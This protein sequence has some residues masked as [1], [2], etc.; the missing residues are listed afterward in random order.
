M[1][2]MNLMTW[3]QCRNVC[4]AW[5]L[6]TGI[7][8]QF[9]K[10]EKGL[11]DLI[12]NTDDK[13]RHLVLMS[14]KKYLKNITLPPTLNVSNLQPCQPKYRGLM[15]LYRVIEQ[16]I[17]SNNRMGSKIR[18]RHCQQLLLSNSIKGVSFFPSS[19]KV[20]DDAGCSV[21]AAQLFLQR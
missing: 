20:M 3:R 18:S 13:S 19:L 7:K 1:W 16:R 10:R 17:P 4:P 2:K 6:I 14:K 9:W 5:L 21:G 15:C 12:R 8:W 11:C